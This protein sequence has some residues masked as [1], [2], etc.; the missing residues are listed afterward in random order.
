MAR[1]KIGLFVF[2][3]GF[4]CLCWDE[5]WRCGWHLGSARGRQVGRADF[6]SVRAEVCKGAI[7]SLSVRVGPSLGYEAGSRFGATRLEVRK[8]IDYETS[9]TT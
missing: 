4:G 3:D 6:W 9:L 2:D 7:L 8:F 1:V 5:G